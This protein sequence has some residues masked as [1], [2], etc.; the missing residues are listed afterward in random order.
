MWKNIRQQYAPEIR[1]QMLQQDAV[2]NFVDD[3]VLSNP[4]SSIDIIL[5]IKLKV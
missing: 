1:K 3:F 2:R 4:V 5:S